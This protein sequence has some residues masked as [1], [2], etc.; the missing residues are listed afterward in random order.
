MRMT[1]FLRIILL[2]C[3]IPLMPLVG[4]CQEGSSILGS[5][6]TDDISLV[7]RIEVVDDQSQWPVKN[8]N[9][10]LR[11][12]NGT[13]TSLYTGSDGVVVVLVKDRSLIFHLTGLEVKAKGYNFLEQQMDLYDLDQQGIR[14]GIPTTNWKKT[15]EMI[16]DAARLKKFARNVSM[17]TDN[18]R[19]VGNYIEIN[20][21]MS[22]LSD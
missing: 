9:V 13:I 15:D 2:F 7:L 10:I 22:G 14:I 21:A 20:L 18:R 8:A 3:A 5:G 16:L 4:I 19:S 12:E 6:S 1:S 17:D 11:G